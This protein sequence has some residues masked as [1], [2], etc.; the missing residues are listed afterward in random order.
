MRMI[1]SL[2]KSALKKPVHFTLPFF[3]G[4]GP[5]VFGGSEGEFGQSGVWAFEKHVGIGADSGA[6]E[7]L[8]VD[9]FDGWRIGEGAE[10]VVFDDLVGGGGGNG[11]LGS[12][13]MG[14]MGRRGSM[15]G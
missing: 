12:G 1:V 3:D 6:H 14:G 8:E 11:W 2:A 5:Q 10:F 4:C 9:R 13:G 15:R 7:F